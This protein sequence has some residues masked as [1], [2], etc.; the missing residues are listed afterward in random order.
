MTRTTEPTIGT[1]LN[2]SATR[3]FASAT[4]NF[5]STDAR[6]GLK[7]VDGAYKLAGTYLRTTWE[8]KTA[9]QAVQSANSTFGKWQISRGK[10]GPQARASRIAWVR[11]TKRQTNMPVIMAPLKI[12]ASDAPADPATKAGLGQ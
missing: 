1:T 7:T 2:L 9:V 5:L 12:T 10:V 6:E 4:T 8:A 11:S 3:Y